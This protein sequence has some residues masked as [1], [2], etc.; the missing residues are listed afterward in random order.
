MA[1]FSGNHQGVLESLLNR[2]EC[3]TSRLE[4]LQVRVCLPSATGSIFTALSNTWSASLQ[5]AS[6]GAAPAGSATAAHINSAAP[7]DGAASATASTSVAD[8]TRLTD[9][10]VSALVE[11]ARPLGADVRLPNHL[12][13]H[14]LTTMFSN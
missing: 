5:G 4:G 10:A 3:V 6:G 7:P 11:A 9:P 2:L 8:Y 13:R 12:L 1:T 14:T